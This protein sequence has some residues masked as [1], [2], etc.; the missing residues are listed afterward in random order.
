VIWVI[1]TLE[2]LA[3]SVRCWAQ[4]WPSKQ[5]VFSCSDRHFS[6]CLE[7][8]FR[9]KVLTDLAR[10]AEVSAPPAPQSRPSR[11]AVRESGRHVLEVALVV[12]LSS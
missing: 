11:G 3:V 5:D 1:L 10:T 4:G 12:S 8:R 9:G 7:V 6:P 2:I